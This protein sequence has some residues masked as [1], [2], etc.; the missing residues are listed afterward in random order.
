MDMCRDMCGSVF[1]CMDVY[2]FESICKTLRI[3]MDVCG[4]VQV[5]VDARMDWCT[6]VHGIY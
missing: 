1:T 2:G 3:Y 4:C 5:C 6:D